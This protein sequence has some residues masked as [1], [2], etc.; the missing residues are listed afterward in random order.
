MSAPILAVD[1]LSVAYAT[2]RGPLQ[3]LSEISFAVAPGEIVGI[4]GESGC[5]KSTL[6]AALMGMLPPS[7]RI[8]GGAIRFAGQDLAALPR[9]TLRALRGGGLALVSQHPMAAF[10]P[11]LTIGRQLVD[12]QHRDRGASAAEKRRRIVE[13]FGRVGITDP[14]RRLDAYPHEFSGGMLQRMAIAAALLTRPRLIV[15]DEPTTALDV[16][17]EAQIIALLRRI[18]DAEGCAILFV[19]HHLGAVAQLCDRVLVMY[20]GAIVEAAPVAELFRHPAHPYTRRLLA[21][22]PAHAA[23]GAAPLPTIAGR[24][25]DLTAPPPGCRFAPRCVCATGRCSCERPAL[26]EVAPA[27][28]SA[29]PVVP[30]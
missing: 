24:L 23:E 22:D 7:A 18:R 14:A 28:L 6:A 1:G 5:G 3:A 21:C 19:S 10:N 25:P 4:I 9:E 2:P 16:T 11:V 13:M 12:F 8:G 26:A 29:C 20:A 27:H 17:L 30:P 15:A